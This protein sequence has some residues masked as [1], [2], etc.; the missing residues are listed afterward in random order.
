MEKKILIQKFWNLV[1]L[2]EDYFSTGFR[3]GRQEDNVRFPEL[4]VT[5]GN[6]AKTGEKDISRDKQLELLKQ[7]ILTCKKCYLHYNRVNAVP[8]EGVLD[9]DLLIVGNGP[10][11]EEDTSGRPF[12]G[13]TG[14][15]LKKWLSAI[16]LDRLKNC[17]TCNIVRCRPPQDRDPGIEESRTCFPYIEKQ[18]SIVKPKMIL[19][20]GR[21]AGQVLTG[22]LTTSAAKLRGQPFSYKGIP[23][24][25]TYHPAFV[26]QDQSL[27]KPVWE[28]LKRLKKILEKRTG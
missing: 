26:L 7:E 19:C 17:F 24:I 5:P 18:I 12:A 20:L 10:D 23:L 11:E 28:D 27:R 3:T 16:Q 13:K 14:D 6:Q 9:A 1:N 4:Q 21:I 8:G 22:K 2:A 15:Y 25:I